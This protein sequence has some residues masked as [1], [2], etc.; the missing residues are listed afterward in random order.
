MRTRLSY[1]LETGHKA[2]VAA[3]FAR[4]V[5]LADLPLR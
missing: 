3:G 4:P 1:I 2:G 5:P